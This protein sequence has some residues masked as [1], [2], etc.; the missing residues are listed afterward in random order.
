MNVGKRKIKTNTRLQETGIIRLM[1]I[2]FFRSMSFSLIQELKKAYTIIN[3][4][5]ITNGKKAPMAQIPDK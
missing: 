5:I 1:L 3:I 2:S 4:Q